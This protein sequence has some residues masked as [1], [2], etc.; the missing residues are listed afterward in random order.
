MHGKM[1]IRKKERKKEREKKERKIERK[2][3]EQKEELE[4]FFP[5]VIKIKISNA[6]HSF[7]AEAIIMLEMIQLRNDWFISLSQIDIK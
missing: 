3:K 1:N 7:V 5:Y 2:K 6:A 4:R